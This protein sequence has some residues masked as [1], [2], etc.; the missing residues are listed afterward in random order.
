VRANAAFIFGGFG[1]ARGLSTLEEI[2]SDRSV[3]PEGQGRAGGNFNVEQQITADRYYTIV[4]LGRLRDSRAISMLVPLL[5][6][7]AVG[8]AVPSALA[9][10]GNP[11]AIAPLIDTLSDDNPSIRVRA[12]YALEALGATEAIPRLTELLQDRRRSN[13]GGQVSVADAA[14]AA[15]ARLQN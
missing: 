6:D 12:I 14:R 1:D 3:R 4:L 13:F 11:S 5:K 7:S 10:I 15:I 9:E 2:L 8:Y